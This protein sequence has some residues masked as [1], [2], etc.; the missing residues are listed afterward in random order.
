MLGI[1]LALIV[2]AEAPPASAQIAVAE[3]DPK[4]MSQKQIREFNAKLPRSHPY[5]IR[6]VSSGEIGSLVRK[7]FSC[8]TNHQWDQAQEKGN[9]NVRD[10][11]DHLASKHWET[12]N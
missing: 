6:C 12:S 3:P 10:T 1:A 11:M 9:Q 2:A 7:T 8:R 4:A 5:Y